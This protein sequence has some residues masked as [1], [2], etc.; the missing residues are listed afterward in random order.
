MAEIAAIRTALVRIGFAQNVAEA[1][2]DAQQMTTLDDFKL[3]T[4]EEAVN[5]CRAIRKPGGQIPNPNAA[6]GGNIPNPGHPVSLKAENNLKLMCYFLRHKERTSR[7]VTAA[8]ITVDNIRA[9]RGCRQWEEGHED[10]AAPELSFK[11]WTRTIE[12]IEDYLRGCLGTTKIPLAHIVPHHDGADPPVFYQTHKDDNI[13]VFNKIAGLTRDKDCWTYV[14]KSQKRRD[15]RQA[16]MALKEH[17]L[18]KNNVDNMATSA[19]NKLKQTTHTGEQRR[20]NFEKHVKVHVDRTWICWDRSPEQGQ[21]P[22]RRD[23]D[24]RV[25]PRQDNHLG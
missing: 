16:F 9:L 2:T 13:T 19:E 22:N 15:G 17:C 6:A 18:G 21:M 8:E 24:D 11:D 23:Q 25:R 4:D 3:F 14:Q 20:W 1:I 10:P 12:T 7:P 5:L